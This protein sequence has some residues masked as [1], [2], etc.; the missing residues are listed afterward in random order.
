MEW[1]FSRISLTRCLLPASVLELET[2]FSDR[3][4]P[5]SSLSEV[6]MIGTILLYDGTN[7]ALICVMDGSLIT[8]IRTGA[9]RMWMMIRSWRVL[10]KRQP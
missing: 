7:G 8:G 5:L 6:T 10:G 9:M 1:F 3:D 2:F 4:D